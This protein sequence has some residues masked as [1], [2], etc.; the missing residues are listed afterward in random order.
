MLALIR[1]K[2]IWFVTIFVVIAA[3]SGGGW[4]YFKGKTGNSGQAAAVYKTQEEGADKYVRFDMEAYDTIKDKYWDKSTD[5]QLAKLFQA[6]LNKAASTTAYTLAT[7]TRAGTAE[8]LASAFFVAGSDEARK[9]IALDTLIVATYNLQPVSRNGLMSSKQEKEL[10]QNVSNINPSTD[11]YKN[12][13]VEKGASPEVV[14]QAYEKKSAELAKL[15]TPEAKEELKQV[16]YAKKVLT[17]TGTKAMYDQA[18]IEPTVVSKIIGRTLYVSMSKISP[19]TLREFG[20]AVDKAST[21]PNLENLIIDLRGNIGGALDFFPAFF[22]LFVGAGQY[23]FD[24]F[25]QGDYQPQRTTL[26]KFDELTRYTGGIAI[27]ADSMTQSTAEVTTAAFKRFRMAKVVGTAT[28]GWGTVENTYPISTELDPTEKYSLFLVN[29]ITLRDDNQPVEGRGVDPDLNTSD[30]G[31]QSKV[32]K[33][34]SSVD[35]AKAVKEA[36][37]IPPL[38]FNQ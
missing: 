13:G 31:W 20:L 4:Y 21:T 15:N 10:R 7:S 34:F 30:K 18:Q 1:Q 14:T 2:I 27:L 3:A 23:S 5:E 12:L 25:H 37:S 38:R 33:L 9:K 16:A 35:L 32:E 28:R 29:S 22:G 36:A 11:L 6:S 24:L 26:Q 19:T 8:M 17:D